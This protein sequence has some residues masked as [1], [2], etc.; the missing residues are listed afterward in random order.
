ML[1]ALKE[2]NFEDF[3]KF[4]NNFLSRFYAEWLIIGNMHKKT[5]IEIVKTAEKGFQSC[6]PN[7]QPLPLSKIPSLRIFKLPDNKTWIYEKY[8][9]NTENYV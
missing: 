1:A 6:R 8:L 9:Y 7:S 5:A 2:I 4:S 3:I